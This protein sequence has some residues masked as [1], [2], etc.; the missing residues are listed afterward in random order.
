MCNEFLISFSAKYKAQFDAAGIWYEHRLIDDMVAQCLKSDGGFE[1]LVNVRSILGGPAGY[2]ERLFAKISDHYVNRRTQNF[3][4][5]ISPYN[6][7][8]CLVCVVET[9]P[10]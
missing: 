10:L 3:L 1:V 5:A 4:R 7:P 2:R 8:D 9:P 6:L